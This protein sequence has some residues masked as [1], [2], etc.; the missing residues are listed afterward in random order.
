MKTK[1]IGPFLGLNNRLPDFSLHVDKVGDFLRVAENI[2]IDAKGNITRRSASALLQALA[3]GHSIHMVGTTTGYLGVGAAL[4]AIT[5][6][7]YTQTLF[8]VLS[9]SNPLSWEETGDDLYYSNGTDSG[10]IT[11]GVWYP[12]GLASPSAPILSAIS[13]GGLLSGR[14]QVGVSYMNSATGEEGGLSDIGYI[15]RTTTGSVRVTLPGAI[16]GATHMNIYLSECNGSVPMWL[17]S[18]TTGTPTYDAVALPSGREASVRAEEVLPPGE[19]FSSNGRLCSFSGSTVYIGL[20]H[21]PGYYL[22]VEGRIPL[23]SP[24]TLAIENQG[25]TY[26][27]T[28]E[29]TFWIPGDL[30][31]VQG[32]LSN[33]LP[34]GA[35]PGTAFRFTDKTLCGWFGNKGIVFGSTTGEVDATMAENVDQTPP[36]RGVSVVLESKG[37]RRVVSCGWCV[38]TETKAATEYTGFDFT[39]ISCGYGTRSDGIYAIDAPGE[40]DSV[41][42]LGRLDFGSEAL[43]RLPYVYLGM[44]SESP[45]ELTVAYVD[46]TGA[47]MEFTYETRG[48]GTTIKMQRI[49]LGRGIR[50]NWLD[51]TLRNT[52]GADFTLASVS[53]TPTAST[54]RI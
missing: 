52:Y 44:A 23:M 10:R 31:D 13:G 16:P 15:D 50:A 29:E 18:V 4:Y 6:P 24:V 26:L 28:E 38:N 39:S 21:R 37:N 7:I 34:Y 2:D 46:D 20:P 19:L 25:G 48:S 40:T 49:D 12:M 42:G 43:K 9:N 30:G 14:Y 35:V 45:M 33:P 3:G 22:P 5:L 32:A 17:D 47:D 41:I 1:P 53:F 8:K 36:S 11:A 54:R 51:L 27:C